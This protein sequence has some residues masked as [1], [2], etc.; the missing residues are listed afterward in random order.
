MATS[1]RGLC[2]LVLGGGGDGLPLIR[3]RRLLDSLVEVGR[4]TQVQMAL[5]CIHCHLKLV[6]EAYANPAGGDPLSERLSAN[7]A[8]RHMQGTDR[9]RRGW[10][11]GCKDNLC[12]Q[13]RAG[14]RVRLLH[15]MLEMSFDRVLAHFHPVR[16]LL[17]C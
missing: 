10:C 7:L 6:E 2:P 1:L 8:T 16:D 15:Q 11:R 4:A 17:V 3:G 12:Q 14:G 13:S 9:H 5:H